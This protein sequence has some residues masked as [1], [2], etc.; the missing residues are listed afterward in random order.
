M[1]AEAPWLSHVPGGEVEGDRDQDRPLFPCHPSV[2]PTFDP[3]GGWKVIGPRQH[4]YEDGI[5]SRSENKL[6]A[7]VAYLHLW[8]ATPSEVVVGRSFSAQIGV[9]FSW[10]GAIGCKWKELIRGRF[11]PNSHLQYLSIQLSMHRCTLSGIN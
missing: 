4:I 1:A 8:H 10:L 5:F 9:A 6:V 3:R 11:P 2:H 7:V